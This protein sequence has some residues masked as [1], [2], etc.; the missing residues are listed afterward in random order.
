VSPSADTI[1]LVSML[2]ELNAASSV[3]ASNGS[4]ASARVAV[5]ISAGPPLRSEVKKISRRSAV[6][7][8]LSLF[9]TGSESSVMSS[10]GPK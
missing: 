5:Q 4:L 3:G 9:A 6:R 10:A 1:G 2:G 7:L 8:G